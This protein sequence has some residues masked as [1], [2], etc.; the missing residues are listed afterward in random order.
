MNETLYQV[1]RRIISERWSRF[2]VEDLGGFAH[3]HLV[4]ADL[5]GDG[6]HRDAEMTIARTRGVV[7]KTIGDLEEAGFEIEKTD[8]DRNFKVRDS[9]PP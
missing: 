9:S 6:G 7:T 2:T 8:S 3:V 5:P 1:V 4:D